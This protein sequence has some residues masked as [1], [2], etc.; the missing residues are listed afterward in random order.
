[1]A[2]GRSLLLGTGGTVLDDP[3][4]AG[5]VLAEALTGPRYGRL[6]LSQPP[7][8]GPERHSAA[9]ARERLGLHRALAILPSGG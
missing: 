9:T 6:P 2:A 5:T 1:M 3:A 7:A 4:A 8:P